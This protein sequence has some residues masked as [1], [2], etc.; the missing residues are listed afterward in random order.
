MPKEFP[1]GH[2]VSIHRHLRV[3][4]IYAVAGLIELRAGNA[5]WLLPPQR[6]VWMPSGVAH[7]MRARGA[8]SLRTLYIQPDACPADFPCTVRA[9]NVSALLRELILRAADLAIDTPESPRESRL[10]AV[11]LDEIEWSP[12]QALHLPSGKDRRLTRICDAILADPSDPRTLAEWA[13]TVG[14]SSRT[15]ARLFSTDLGTPFL[16]WRQQARLLQALPRLAGG[17]SVTRV[18]ADLGYETSGAFSAMFR[19][20]IGTTPSHYAKMSDSA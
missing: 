13:H 18:A 16:Q 3:Q 20:Y 12:E 4:L 5:L 2:V 10:M 7:Q 1:D 15:L 6:A 11:L 14:A 19:R 8:V 17:E 9:V